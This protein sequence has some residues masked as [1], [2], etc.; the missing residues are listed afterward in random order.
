MA[1]YM[2]WRPRWSGW[3]VRV[4]CL[5][6]PILNAV[7]QRGDLFQ[8]HPIKQFR[9][10]G[11]D[12]RVRVLRQAPVSDGSDQC[13][14]TRSIAERTAGAQADNEYN[15]EQSFHDFVFPECG[16]RISECGQDLGLR[17][18]NANSEL[19]SWAELNARI[20]GESTDP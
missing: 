19:R 9:H 20:Y 5:W 14:P 1:D 11:F 7:R 13:V 10:F 15:R 8:S 17:K 12:G 3:L 6:I 4:R 18:R 16:S 2:E